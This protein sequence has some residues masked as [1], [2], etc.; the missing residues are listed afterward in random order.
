MIHTDRSERASLRRIFS[1]L[2]RF[3]AF[4][5][6]LL[7]GDVKGIVLADSL[8]DPHVGL[9]GLGGTSRSVLV[10]GDVE[11]P[12][13]KE[14]VRCL[15][16]Q[17]L[18][19]A[20]KRSWF[21]LITAIYGETVDVNKSVYFSGQS[22]ALDRLRRLRQAFSTGFYL[23]KID[24]PLANELG[25]GTKIY[26]WFESPA[27][28]VQRGLGYCMLSGENI[29]S[30]ALTEVVSSSAVEVGIW[31]G[32]TEHRRK[33]LAT[34]V[35]AALLVDCLEQGL[36]P[37]WTTEADNRASLRLA[38]KLGYSTGELYEAWSLYN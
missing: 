30:G 16:K 23:E 28:F 29:I 32:A 1:G 5:D 15:P 37:E 26:Q 27:E 25:I 33:G 24:V 10:A 4:T 11:H 21:E 8:Q 2:D 31:T 12:A 22:L 3:H 13:A 14:L 6:C 7:F 35:G 38:E 20:D 34:S 36:T 18:V 17:A 9:I 19:I